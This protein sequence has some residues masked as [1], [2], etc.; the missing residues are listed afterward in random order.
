M[1]TD[2]KIKLERVLE[3]ARAT[4]MV[5][6]V[7]ELPQT[8]CYWIGRLGDFCKSPIKNYSKQHKR[9]TDIATTK[10]K[11]LNE[12]YQKLEKKDGDEGK[13]LLVKLQEVDEQLTAKLEELLEAEESIKMPE[14]KITDFAAIEDLSRV[15]D[16]T[17]KNEKGESITKKVEIKVKKGQSLVPIAFYKL[18]GEYIKE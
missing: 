2:V 5:G 1:V 3:L 15:Y 14:F 18:M 16:V 7:D 11:P 4:E 12:E 17:E 13:A 9:L 8:T 10:R 6:V